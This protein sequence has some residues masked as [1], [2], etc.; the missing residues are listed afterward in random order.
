MPRQLELHALRAFFGTDKMRFYI[1][2][3]RFP[4]EKRY[5]SRFS[6][7]I[8]VL[9]DARVWAGIH[10]RTADVQAAVL[11]KVAR[12]MQNHSSAHRLRRQKR[13]AAPRGPSPAKERQ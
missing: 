4:G 5:F 7:P 2:S 12:Y 9:I 1:T 8:S 6:D 11:G 10:F 13:G 3:S